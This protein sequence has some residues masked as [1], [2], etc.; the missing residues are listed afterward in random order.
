MKKFLFI[1]LLFSLFVINYS[2]ADE[3]CPEGYTAG[4]VY[5]E[6]P[7]FECCNWTQ[8]NLLIKFCCKW[9]TSTNG[10][11]LDVIIRETETYGCFGNRECCIM[12]LYQK[13]SVMLEIQKLIAE[14]QECLSQ[15]PPCPDYKEDIIFKVSPCVYL[16][17]YQKYPNDDFITVLIP[18]VENGGAKCEWLWHI[19]M[20]YSQN[21]PL[22]KAE[23]QSCTPVYPIPCDL[24]EP[25]LP[26][27]G[28][29]WDEYWITNCFI[30]NS[31]CPQ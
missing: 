15:F 1:F 5:Y 19:C 6:S 22:L 9:I 3:E 18:C 21:P 8:C 11:F 29:S 27:D 17:N 2:Y 4:E 24:V 25:T 12:C 7:P 13:P 28:K 16:K 10:N 20:D 30:N 14:S 23:F 26:P 31:C